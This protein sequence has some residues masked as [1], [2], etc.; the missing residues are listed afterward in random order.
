MTKELL[1]E[2]PWLLFPLLIAL[3]VWHVMKEVRDRRG[4]H[5]RRRQEF[6]QLWEQGRVKDDLWLEAAIQHLV[7][8]AIPA[9]VVRR[10]LRTEFSFAALVD[11]ANA[12]KFL[13]IENGSVVWRGAWMKTPSKRSFGI[14][15]LMGLYF[16]AFFGMCVFGGL[17]AI[18]YL[19]GGDGA[20]SL[21]HA[22]SLG[23]VT[24]FVAKMEADLSTASRSVPRWLGVE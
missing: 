11:V 9:Q 10:L 17:G 23:V 5:S 12:W 4:V 2:Y 8:K 21:I 13:Q 20:A 6:L 7:G 18:E 19:D 3:I 16:V 1:H 15:C 22:V 14:G 24:A